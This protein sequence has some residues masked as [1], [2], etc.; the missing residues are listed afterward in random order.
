MHHPHISFFDKM[1]ASCILLLAVIICGLLLVLIAA[2]ISCLLRGKRSMPRSKF[3]LPSREDYPYIEPRSQVSD[4]L[5]PF[6][7]N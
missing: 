1:L 4:G 7:E 3:K 6:S 5:P 2:L